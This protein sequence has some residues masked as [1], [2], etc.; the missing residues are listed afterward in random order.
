MTPEE[1]AAIAQRIYPVASWQARLA[2]Y[3]HVSPSTVW[4][5][6]SGNV[7]IPHPVALA[8]RALEEKI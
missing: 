8:V 4:R 7:S 1:L 3:L 2:E 6:V 5:W